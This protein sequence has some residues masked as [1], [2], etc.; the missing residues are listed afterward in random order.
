[1]PAEPRLLNLERVY[2]K[3]LKAFYNKIVD[4]TRVNGQKFNDQD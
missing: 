1:M 4:A 2:I 3:L